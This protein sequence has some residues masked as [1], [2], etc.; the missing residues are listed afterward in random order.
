[1]RLL[2]GFEVKN[3]FDPLTPGQEGGDPDNDGL[4]N[5]EEQS[6]GTDPRNADT[7]GDGLTDGQEVHNVH[8]NPSKADTDGDGLTDGAEIGVY[9]TDPLKADTDGGGV[10]DGT[11]VN[12]DHTNPLDPKDD[13]RPGF[14]MVM[15]D[16]SN[17]AIVFDAGTNVIAGS[18]ALGGDTLGIGDCVL[19][20]D[21]TLGYATDFAS[22]IW[23][24]DVRATPP[25]L[26]AGTNPIP[27][28]NPGEDVA[29]TA[30]GKYLVVCDGTSSDPIAV[31][32]TVTRTLRSIFSLGSDCTSVDVCDD[33]SVLVTSY[34]SDVV[35]RLKLDPAGN[36]SDTGDRLTVGAPDNAY[37]APGSHTG[38][39]LDSSQSIV[40]SFTIPGLARVNG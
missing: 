11:E 10:N 13:R 2:D 16:G 12:I 24:I 25:G 31:V 28:S 37:C 15:D 6:A 29:L 30:D 35:R 21:G 33:G 23:V 26:A 14:A 4:S 22:R 38:V 20:S 34:L 18:V 5:L 3:G 32:D 27:I 8:T 19:S 7:D 36:L 40:Q 39:V 1:E 17:R 9:G